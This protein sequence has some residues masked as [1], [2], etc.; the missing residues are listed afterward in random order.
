MKSR[1]IKRASIAFVAA[2]VAFGV[3]VALPCRTNTVD[4]SNNTDRTWTV[5]L[6]VCGGL[7][8]AEDVGPRS[9]RAAGIA[10]HC[11]ESAISVKAR[12]K[13]SRSSKPL[14]GAF[15]YLQQHI[16]DE[17]KVLIER[18]GLRYV[19]EPFPSLFALAYAQ[20]FGTT[21]CWAG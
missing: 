13:P 2:V 21:R 20:V 4:V 14:N 9:A 8:W 19:P 3:H 11:G 16:P 18:S 6:S 5:E 15:G 12:P 17:G 7:V 10:M 1:F